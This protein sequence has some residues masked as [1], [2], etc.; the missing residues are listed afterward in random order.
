MYETSKATAHLHINHHRSFANQADGTMVSV[1]YNR[2][3]PSTDHQPLRQSTFRTRPFAKATMPAG[4]TLPVGI[5]T[6]NISTNNM[7]T[8]KISTNKISTNNMSTNKISTDKISSNNMS[9]NNM[10]TNKMSTK[11]MSTKN[12]SETYTAR[13]AFYGGESAKTKVVSRPA[14]SVPRILRH[15]TTTRP[16]DGYMGRSN[17]ALAFLDTY[18]TERAILPKPHLAVATH[19][20]RTLAANN[21]QRTGAKTKHQHENQH[22]HEG[23]FANPPVDF[24]PGGS[25]IHGSAHAHLCAPPHPAQE[26]P[27]VGL[28]LLAVYSGC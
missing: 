27:F 24:V 26:Q 15:S 4:N 21:K 9:T 17:H 16:Y 6:N 10:S 8:S 18:S 7:S 28:V 11:N 20:H 12:M 3:T 22:Q 19:G 5:F 13:H 25:L 14:P 1:M 23:H 2:T